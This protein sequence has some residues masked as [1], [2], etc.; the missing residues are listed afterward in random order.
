MYLLDTDW[1]IQALAAKQP[2]ARTL[3]RLIGSSVFV[4]YITH[5]EVYERAFLS[6]NPQAHLIGFRHF[7]S[8]YPALGLDDQIMERFAETRAFL[9][10]RGQG[11]ADL[12]LLIGATALHHDLTLLTFNVRHFARIPDLKLYQPS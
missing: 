1:V 11:I 5:G 6:A 3:D 8:G 9:R 2:A 10:R 12:D 7:L 4:S